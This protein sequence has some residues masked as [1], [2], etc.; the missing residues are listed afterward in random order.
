[1][2]PLLN[3]LTAVNERLATCST[4]GN[5]DTHDPCSIC[6][7][8]RR[9]AR[10][11]CVVEDVADLWALDRAHESRLHEKRR[12]ALKVADLL[13]KPTDGAR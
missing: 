6:A 13:E 11:L 2:G 9:D 5:V 1:M 12:D 3:A 8:P 7:D 4:C 10:A